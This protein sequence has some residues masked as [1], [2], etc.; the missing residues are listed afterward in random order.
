[1]T[2]NPMPDPVAR[3]EERYNSG[4][5]PWDTQITPPEVREF[6]ASGRLRP[7]EVIGQFALDLGCGTGTNSAFLAELGLNVF[8][9]DLSLTALQ[10]GQARRTKIVPPP[11]G[12]M[13][14]SQASV[15]RLPLPD[16]GAVYVLDIGCLHGVPVEARFDYAK[17]LNRILRPGG[18]YQLYAHDGAETSDSTRRGLAPHEAEHL[19][20]QHLE[21]VQIRQADPSPGP[22][23]WYLLR[24]PVS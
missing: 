12:N 22:C 17:G 9:F 14:L 15:D 16:L 23:K 7:A 2:N 20:A 3:W 21:F 5:T 8:G 4:P 19:F 11:L 18:Y 24:K 10:R 13:L 6:W 1:M